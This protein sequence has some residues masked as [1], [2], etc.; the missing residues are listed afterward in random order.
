MESLWQ[1][2]WICSIVIDVIIQSEAMHMK[3]WQ[4]YS[5]H[6]LNLQTCP[7]FNVLQ[8]KMSVFSFSLRFSNL[9][10]KPHKEEKLLNVIF[11][12]SHDATVTNADRHIYGGYC[13]WRNVKAIPHE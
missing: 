2:P 8:G 4:E 3:S 1:A 5:T 10:I 12:K 11:E 13:S 6:S 7:V 9:R